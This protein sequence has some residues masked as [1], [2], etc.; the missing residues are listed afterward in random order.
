MALGL[1]CVIHQLRNW[2][3]LTLW[4]KALRVQDVLGLKLELRLVLDITGIP[5]L[6]VHH[7]PLSQ[8]FVEVYLIVLTWRLLD[9]ILALSRNQSFLNELHLTIVDHALDV[10]HDLVL[11]AVLELVDYLVLVSFVTPELISELSDFRVLFR[12]GV[13]R[14]VCAAR[15]TLV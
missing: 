1:A 11:L 7:D 2:L 14:I 9:L 12:I 6:V 3:L 15:Q 13:A 10:L 8:K 4:D 5:T